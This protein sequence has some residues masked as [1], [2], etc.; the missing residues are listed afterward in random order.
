M[1]KFLNTCCS[2]RQLGKYWIWIS[3]GSR[4]HL[5]HCMFSN[6]T[7]PSW[8]SATGTGVS[9]KHSYCHCGSSSFW[10]M[11]S[12]SFQKEEVYC[13]VMV[14]TLLSQGL[15]NN[16]LEA[17]LDFKIHDLPLVSLRNQF[18][19][20]S[21]ASKFVHWVQS[22]CQVQVQGP[23]TVWDSRCSDGD[24]LEWEGVAAVH[25]LASIGVA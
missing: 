23:N 14:V 13:R 19:D 11:L 17:D 10:A 12:E 18:R 25:L 6:W 22:L 5:P 4:D 8:G 24:D 3:G 1:Y 15:H 21:W 2:L 20:Y 16:K 7:W 9:W